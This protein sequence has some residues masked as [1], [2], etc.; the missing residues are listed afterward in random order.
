[1]DFQPVFMSGLSLGKRHK[2]FWQNKIR[3][4]IVPHEAPT[5]SVCGFKAEERRL[6]HA[7]EVWRFPGPPHASLINIRAL[8]VYC[9]DAKDYGNLL[10]RIQW[11]V[12]AARLAGV[13]Q[14]HYC[15]INGCTAEEFDADYKSALEIKH[16]LENSYGY[17]CAVEVDYGKWTPPPRPPKLPSLTRRQRQLVRAL[18]KGEAPVELDRNGDP[19]GGGSWER[20]DPIVV[21]DRELNGFAVA[22]KFLQ[23]LP[24]E[25]REAVIEE[26]K[27]YVENEDDCDDGS[28]IYAHNEGLTP[29]LRGIYPFSG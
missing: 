29:W 22:V 20:D 12:A 24:L 3:P 5:C 27:Q 28:W 9:H 1:M 14:K 7:D 16:K 26:M 13:V 6:I 8:C 17:N 11:G 15:K 21:R 4:S 18:Y 23:S 19:I 25:E 10:L 2:S